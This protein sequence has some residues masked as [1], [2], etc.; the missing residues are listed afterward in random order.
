MS[1]NL[2]IKK[3]AELV[4]P[5]TAYGTNGETLRIIP[6]EH[7]DHLNEGVRFT[8]EIQNLIGKFQ[9]AKSVQ[10]LSKRLLERL[11]EPQGLTQEESRNLTRLFDYIS[12]LFTNATY[13]EKGEPHPE[14]NIY[15]NFALKNI[16][17]PLAAINEKA[18]QKIQAL[19]NPISEKRL[20]ELKAQ[21]THLSQTINGFKRNFQEAFSQ[22]A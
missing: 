17:E 15:L 2:S 7:I 6:I 5:Q 14:K 22:A 11:N 13:T 18:K 21:Q 9:D 19:L 10:N 16:L 3:F 1:E 8:R 4:S 20:E 12:T